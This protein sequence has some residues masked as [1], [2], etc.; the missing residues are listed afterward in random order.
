MPGSVE[1]KTQQARDRFGRVEG[2]REKYRTTATAIQHSHGLYAA[3]FLQVT[4]KKVKG[5]LFFPL[6]S[7]LFLLFGGWASFPGEKL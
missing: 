6:F 5:R 3:P 1:K 4:L 7:F 2:V